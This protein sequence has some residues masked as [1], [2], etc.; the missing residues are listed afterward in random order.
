MRFSS[1]LTGP[2]FLR[3]PG[4]T[5]GWRVGGA[6]VAS[7]A[8]A[9][10]LSAGLIA[11]TG[12]SPI[13]S[14]RAIYDGSVASQDAWT[15][16]LLYVAPLLLVAVGS[17][18]SS[19]A[20]VFNIGQEGQVMIGALTGAWVGLR[21]AISGP[22]LL[23]LVALGAAAGGAMWAGLCALMY[24]TRGVNVV[25]STLLMTF[26]AAQVVSYAVNTSWF[27]QESRMNGGLVSSESNQLPS[28]ARLGSFGH[29]PDLRI[30][31]GLIMA[32]VAA[33]AV[34][35]LL[36]RTRWGFRLRLRGLNPRVAQHAGVRVVAL[37]A[38]ALMISGAFAGLAG[39]VLLASPVGTNR[40]QPNIS[41]NIGW[42]GLLV[43]LVARQRPVVAIPVALLFGA[44]RS[45]GSY[46][47]ATG[48]PPYL[49]DVV[50]SLLVLAFVLPGVLVTMLDRRTRA[51]RSTRA[52]S[53]RTVVTSEVVA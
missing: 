6:T 42:D 7:V 22:V 2:A 35:L 50:K 4:A 31:G 41:A 15:T 32:L 20:G 40:L 13:A 14:A 51:A 1:L 46:L 5:H 17:C 8:I 23:V 36:A 43:A 25:V 16:T 52:V 24:R 34:A 39:M 37:G 26:I 28:A 48:V 19:S 53:S 10:A 33:G 11:W 47:A 29:Y 44:L 45:G 27:L 3:P 30:N 38:I 12:D 18:I 49:V 21:L 9:L